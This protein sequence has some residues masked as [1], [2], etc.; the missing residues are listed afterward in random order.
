MEKL[1]IIDS[2]S[3]INRAFYGV[4][5]LSAKDGTPTN[6]IFG[7]LK[8]L[9]KLVEENNP[10]YILAAF[11]LK[12]PT[13]R[14][15]MFDAYKAQRKPM[16][17]DLA[18]QMPIAKEILTKMGIKILEK[19]GFEADDI[20]GTVSQIC[21]DKG[22]EC[23]IATGDKD[24]LQ[25]ASDKTKVI[26]TVTKS[27]V[28]ETVY[29]GAEQV[30]EK[31]GVTPQEFIDVKALMG[32]SSDN[33]P[34]VPGIGEKTALSLIQKNK[35][36]EYIYE[37]IDGIG[38]KGAMLEKLKKG[39]DSAFLS[40]TLATIVR[41]VPIDSNFSDC[42]FPGDISALAT[43]DAAEILESL[44]LESILKKLNIT[45]RK[46][47]TKLSESEFVKSAKKVTAES[48]AEA[49]E[50]ISEISEKKEV[51]CFFKLSGGSLV[52]A[53]FAVGKSAYFIDTDLH[54]DLF[55]M[56][57]PVL[58]DES[59]KK[60]TFDV[61]DAL[62]ALSDKVKI[63]GIAYDCAVAAYLINP[64]RPQ[65][66]IDGILPEFLGLTFDV[67]EENAQISLFDTESSSDDVS[68][69]VL[70]IKPLMEKTKEQ[71]VKNGQEKLYYDVELPLVTVLADMQT[72]GIKIDTNQL[73]SFSD[74][75]SAR[76]DE[77][78]QSIYEL[79]GEEFNINSTKQLGVILFEK[80]G[81]KS[82]KKT[83]TGYSTNID[84]LEKLKGDHAIINLL[85]EYRQLTKLKSTYC[86]GL[87]NVINPRTG[88][89]HSQF[90]QLVTVT[91]RIS[92]TEPNMQNI[93]VRTELGRELRKMFI[94]E[95]EDH[96]LVDADY[97]QIELR[98]LAHMANDK[99]MIE[100]FKNNEDIHA[101]T[102]SQVLGIPISEIT[103]EQRSS[104]KAVNFGIVYGIGE[105]SLS[106]DLGISVKAAKEYINSYLDKYMGVREY[107]E[108]IKAEAKEDGFVKTAMNRI[109]YIPE[110]KSTNFNTRSFGERVA[111]NTPIQ[112]TAADIIKLAMVRVHKRLEKE[113][114]KAR[115]I[116]QVH[117]EL[118][119]EA[120]K[121]EEDAVKKLLKE[122][123]ENAFPLS[124]PLIA[125][126]S[127][128]RSW[129]DA[130]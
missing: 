54:P 28:N 93:P 86:D 53:G 23:L 29:Y 70:A 58:S 96:V 44:N 79:A 41:D 61:K 128:G 98:V 1:L 100:A 59:I 77:L 81:L 104:A 124:V 32:D 19:E 20:I 127:S 89:I 75:L 117:D 72:D 101:V 94:A 45:E 123:M 129:Y 46:A 92:S 63:K 22:I 5:Y 116:L 21:E 30:F 102:A 87:M 31:Y 15:K 85:I 88:R 71:I 50:L 111:L 130:K 51:S 36:I 64:A 40:K 122:E 74:T 27:G 62:V 34:G 25:L 113:G 42:T 33:I 47:E 24:D 9:F 103:P 115:L 91:G 76:I 39:K 52:S 90:K 69:S 6:A 105:Y 108:H 82:G 48:K 120:P 8:T 73:K 114:Y 125:D 68:M 17:D 95:D 110:L 37:N 3:I 119:V 10:D 107:M 83:K 109:R 55:E 14:H 65:Y 18:R 57:F 11:D 43:P 16:P 97:S 126:T 7:F 118:I 13:F 35:N 56:L 26:L 121:S 112:G 84:V 99:T 80:L 106:Q 66:T 12:A 67:G 60:Y 78:T 49:D 4:R 2:N 38:L